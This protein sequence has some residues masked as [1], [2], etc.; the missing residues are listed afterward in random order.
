MSHHHWHGGTGKRQRYGVGLNAEVA[1]EA[2]REELT[3]SQPASKRDVRSRTKD[4]L[5]GDPNSASR[6]DFSR[7]AALSVEDANSDIGTRS[8]YPAL[9]E[10]CSREGH[11]PRWPWSRLKKSSDTLAP[12]PGDGFSVV[13]EG[14]SRRVDQGLI[15]P[16]V[17]VGVAGSRSGS[18]TLHR[19]KAARE[20]RRRI[21]TGRCRC[22]VIHL[23][24]NLQWGRLRV[25]SG[26]Q[27]GCM[28][29]L[30]ASSYRRG[31]RGDSGVPI[32][33]ACQGPKTA[34]R[35]RQIAE[36]RDKSPTAT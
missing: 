1:L 32:A 3:I 7:F 17:C 22:L 16:A 20:V 4:A 11:G 27:V 8:K 29:A 9:S 15:R 28:K 34:L 24:P 6:S 26:C 31:W 14:P 35:S 23:H 36:N 30:E 10:T 2:T 33:S 5:A 13:V 19:W 25:P 21:L 12:V 18:S